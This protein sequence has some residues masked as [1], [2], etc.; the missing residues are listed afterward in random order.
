MPRLWRL[1]RAGHGAGLD[2]FGATL[3][4]GRW[5]NR[6]DRVVY[7]GASAAITVIERLAHTDADLLPDDLRLAQFEI[8]PASIAGVE[9][10]LPAGWIRDENATRVIGARWWRE[11]QSCLLLVPSAILPEEANFVLNS[12]HP[13]AKSLR[14]SG[15]RPFR[16]DPRLI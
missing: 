6:G 9:A 8:E 14:P 3:A 10:I 15:E 4:D 13:E 16:F 12:Q 5:H 2:G 1:Y 7:F 11:R